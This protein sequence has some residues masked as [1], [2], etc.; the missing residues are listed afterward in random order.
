MI[1]AV[2]LPMTLNG[3]DFSQQFSYSLTPQSE[4]M[5]KVNGPNAGREVLDGTEWTDLRRV[6]YDLTATILPMSPEKLA[7]LCAILAMES[8][9]QT[10]FSGMRNQI[11]TRTVIVPAA[12]V[13][14]G[15][16]K[17]SGRVPLYA[18]MPVTF[19]EK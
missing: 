16:I 12:D 18:N 11:A 1:D 7:Q 9:S 3:V 15:M 13:V 8:F 14:L 5:R 2:Y 10:Y 6:K 19:R 4:H 17:Q